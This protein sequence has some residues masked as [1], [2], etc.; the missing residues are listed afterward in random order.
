LE[1]E[2]V[3]LASFIAISGQ[4]PPHKTKGDHRRAGSISF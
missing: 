4:S 2:V 3:N 1:Y